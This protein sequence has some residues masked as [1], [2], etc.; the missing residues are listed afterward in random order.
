MS[1]LET[2]HRVVMS[3][4]DLISLTSLLAQPPTSRIFCKSDVFFLTNWHLTEVVMK[5]VNKIRPL[6]QRTYN[7]PL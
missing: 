3:S 5:A 6:N 4:Y 1:S 7:G 2:E